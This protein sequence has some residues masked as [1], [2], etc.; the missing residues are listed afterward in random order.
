MTES[1]WRDIVLLALCWIGY[2][3]LHSAL[4]SLAAK[5]GVAAAWPQL[6]PYY[7]LTYNILA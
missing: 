5:R 7:R 2:F 4:A 3:A 1:A 6:M